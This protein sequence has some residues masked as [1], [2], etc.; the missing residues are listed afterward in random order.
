MQSLPYELLQLIASNLLPRYQCRLA[1][2][3]RHHHRYLYTPL[4]RWHA[5]KHPI[6]PPK[7]KYACGDNFVYSSMSL[8]EFNE[9]LLLYAQLYINK[10]EV[11]NLTYG[12]MTTVTS[13]YIH[14]R[15]D[16]Y[17][18][19]MMQLCYF[20]QSSNILARCYKYIHKTLLIAYLG[21]KHPLLSLPDE[22]LHNIMDMLSYSDRKAFITSS[23]YLR[24]LYD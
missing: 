12:Y 3:S 15:N 1:M 22:I 21:S 18:I 6:L 14:G 19:D 16:M 2:A 7:H 24:Y 9:Q 23:T 10:L 8:I 17:T 5:K 4:L 20:I 11:Y 13:T